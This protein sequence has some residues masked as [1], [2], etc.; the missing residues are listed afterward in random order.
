MTK[1]LL[2]EILSLPVED[3]IELADILLQ[4]LNST[5]D[6]EIEK[7]WIKESEKK[8]DAYK[9]DEIDAIDGGDFISALRK[10]ISK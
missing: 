6:P 4:S 5:I 7:S 3:R 9:K 8:F 10:R 1:Q 2:S